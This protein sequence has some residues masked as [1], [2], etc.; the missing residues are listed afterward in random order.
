MTVIE[1][2]VKDVTK[3]EILNCDPI[4]DRFDEIFG[5]I[6][7][8]FNSLKDRPEEELQ[9]MLAYEIGMMPTELEINP[10]E[11]RQVTQYNP[12]NYSCKMSFDCVPM[13]QALIS[14]VASAAKG[15][16][17]KAYVLGK[18]ALFK[19]IESRYGAYERFQRGLMRTEQRREG[20]T[21]IPNN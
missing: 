1:D 14:R 3:E 12:N 20:I 19:V 8:E 9:M 10:S 16:K 6:D 2:L 15:E 11:T 4:R 5:E 17:L 13:Y 7:P 18:A 21:P